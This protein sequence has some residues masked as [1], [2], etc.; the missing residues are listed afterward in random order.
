M[1]QPSTNESPVMRS[2]RPP[3]TI[4]AFIE[5]LALVLSL[6]LAPAAHADE[7]VLDNA[8]PGVQVSGPWVSTALTPGFTGSDYLFRPAS[9]GGATVFWP[10]PSGNGGG[11]YEVYARW[12]SGPNRATNAPYW[13]ASEDGTVPVP[14]NQQENGGSWQL[15]GSF[16]FQSGKSQGVTLSDSADGVVIADALRW[17]GPLQD[18]PRAPATPQPA[19][20]PTTPTP[21]LPAA[22]PN[23]VWTVV[24]VD[25]LA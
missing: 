7:I 1:N 20:P 12:T 9:G 5:A 2:R 21:A 16:T 23:G 10:F 22:T 15:L 14:R 25:S 4:V 3:K 6:A 24:L 11:R 18:S 13:I 19:Q 8:S 17:V